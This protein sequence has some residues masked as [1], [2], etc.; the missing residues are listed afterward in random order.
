MFYGETIAPDGVLARHLSYGTDWARF[1]MISKMNVPPDP[2][3]VVLVVEDDPILRMNAVF[4]AG[5]AGAH[6]IEAQNADEA[7]LILEGRK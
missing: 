2:L 4:I 5:D 7:I 1:V 6:V 3:P